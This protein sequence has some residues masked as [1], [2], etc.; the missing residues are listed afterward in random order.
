MKVDKAFLEA[1]E[2]L[3]KNSIASHFLDARIILAKIL[4]CDSQDII[5][6]YSQFDLEPNQY[7]KYLHYINLRAS[8]VPLSHI[9]NHREFFGNHFFVDNS[10]LDPRPDSET[11]VE[12]LLDKYQ[13]RQDGLK[14]CDVAVGSGCLIISLLKLYK[15]WLGVASD[16]SESALKIA[17]KN[18]QINDVDSRI[19]FVKSD[20]FLNFQKDF[21]FDIIISNPPYIPSSEIENLQDEVKIYE[22]RIALDGGFDGLEFYRK[23]ADN[24]AQFLKIYGSI[25]LEIGY[26]QYNEVIEIFESRGLK[27]LD[28]RKDLNGIIRVLEFVKQI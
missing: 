10:V 2:I 15:N 8:R 24:C 26:N 25:F 7:Q 12:M 1:V 14:I 28:S 11:L 22:P 21:L 18:A 13:N 17:Q 19:S 3:K 4:S 5:L 9:T 6:K 20:I 23:I 16:I 27:F